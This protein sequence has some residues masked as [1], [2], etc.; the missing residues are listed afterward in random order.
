MPT[1]LTRL[2]LELQS[3]IED[4]RI[5]AYTEGVLDE[6]YYNSTYPH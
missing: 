4:V 2:E 1:V 3:L 6:R 5:D